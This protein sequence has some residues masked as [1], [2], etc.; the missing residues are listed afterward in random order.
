[1]CELLAVPESSFYFLKNSKKQ[2]ENKKEL[3]ELVF[4]HYIKSRKIYGAGKI[5]KA[6]K[7]N[8]IF[9]YS[10]R[11]IRNAMSELNI[12]SVYRKY[13]RKKTIT[14]ESNGTRTYSENYLKQIFI[15]KH[16]NQIWIGD[17]TYIQTDEGWCYL[18]TVM[19]L[20]SRK[21]IGYSFSRTNN[22]KNC[23][24]AYLMAINRRGN[25]TEF[26]Y[27]SDRGSTY[28]SYE[29]KSLLSV[30]GVTQSMSRTGNCY[31]NSVMESFFK[32]LKIEL[33]YE[34]RYRTLYSAKVSVSEWVEAFYN[35][36]RMHSSL[37]DLSPDEFE[38]LYYAKVA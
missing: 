36:Y 29:F 26:I 20:Y 6:F 9:E 35:S 22:S 24:G 17:V 28:S 31:D 32:T 21:I 34:N 38:A 8:S 33:I 13:R 37:G 5:W 11:D 10:L 2:T 1:M 27:H 14:T 30:Y 19:D 25:P 7:K 18:A 15:A 16:P 12:S 4:K 3:H 23:C